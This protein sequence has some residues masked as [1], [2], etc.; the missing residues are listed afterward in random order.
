MD[1]IISDYTRKVN[2]PGVDAALKTDGAVMSRLRFE[3]SAFRQIV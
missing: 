1:L 2:S 3:S